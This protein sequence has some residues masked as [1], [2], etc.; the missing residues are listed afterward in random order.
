MKVSRTDKLFYGVGAFGYGSVNQTLNN[1]LMF[2]GTGV[3]GLSGT[4]MGLAIAIS[5]VWDAVTDPLVGAMSDNFRGRLGKRH[6]F[7]LVGCVMVAVINLMIW[8]INP[9]WGETRKFLTLLIGLLLI[10]TFNTVYSTPYSALGFDMCQTYHERTSI[11]SYKTVFQSAA[12]LVPSVLMA[13][14]LNPK[15]VATMH[16]AS[17][18]YHVI[19]TIT[20][21]LCIIT[22][23]ITIL[24]TFR[25][26]LTGNIATAQ[27]ARKVS[28]LK[29]FFAI[30]DERNRVCLI[31][32]YAVALS[33][34]AFLTTLG[35][36]VFTYTFHF[37]TWQISLVLGCLV[38]GVIGGQPLW[39]RVSAHFGK[40]RT[41]QTALWVVLCGVVI[42]AGLLTMRIYLPRAATL[43]ILACD[44]CLI[45]VGVG[46][47]YSLPISMFADNIQLDN[48]AMATGFL[49]FC[50][51]CTNAIVTFIVGLLLDLIGFQSGVA[52]QTWQVST[53]L[54]WLLVG[55]VTVAGLG[56]WF[57]FGKY[58]DKAATSVVSYR[59]EPIQAVR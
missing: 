46:C 43:L 45:A 39:C 6:T 42:F 36:H 34:S 16:T 40:K 1:F 23:L 29:E 33:C 14:V 18:G 37:T 17:S 54:G 51:K 24:G 22:A 59:D 35:M 32:A 31:T 11:Q 38:A 30:L 8:H 41:V 52:T 48:T 20:S 55:G 9:A 56:A 13:L 25:Y 44:I 19:A 15:A 10:E 27:P 7:M 57:L 3:L 21:T 26:R 53:A 58:Q 50:T 2:F 5:T 12:L 4:L 47:I 49:T 28:F